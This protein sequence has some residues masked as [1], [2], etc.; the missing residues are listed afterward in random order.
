M[1][2]AQDTSGWTED[3]SRHFIDYGTW[4]VPERETQIDTIC[5]VIPPAPD[6]AVIV[7]V[8][9]GEGLLCTVPGAASPPPRSMRSTA[10]RRCSLPRSPG[11]RQPA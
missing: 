2:D 11:S 4:F 3:D 9:C 5:C 10:R 7:D 6:G 8:G 1:I